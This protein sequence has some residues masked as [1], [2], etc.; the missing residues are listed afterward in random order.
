MLHNSLF[1]YKK[2]IKLVDL[3][4]L[5]D[6]PSAFDSKNNWQIETIHFLK[7]FIKDISKPI[8]DNI[9]IIDYVPTQIVTEYIR[10]N[11]QLKIDGLIY[12]SSKDNEKEN[13]VL[14]MDHEESIEN[15]NFFP[16]SIQIKNI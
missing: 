11:P 14:F 12:P 7:D 8:H 10:F 15:L 2:K 13:Y 1:Y 6:Y 5:P 9:A 16:K 4:K 3:T